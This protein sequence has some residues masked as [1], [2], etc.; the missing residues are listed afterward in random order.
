MTTPE[1]QAAYAGVGRVA[2]DRSDLSYDRPLTVDPARV[3]IRMG[4]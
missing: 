3:G 2:K 4:I 1:S